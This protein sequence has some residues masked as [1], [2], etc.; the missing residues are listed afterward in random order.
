[1][2]A[3]MDK[4]EVVIAAPELR[5]AVTEL[6]KYPDLEIGVDGPAGTGKTFGILYFI[7][8]LLLTYPGAKWLVARKRNTDLA[9]SALATY[10]ESILDEREGVTFF[11]GS[12][13][14]P[15]GF[16]YPNGSFLAVNGLDRPG[17]VKSMDFDGIYINEATD[18]TLDDVEM[19]H[20][21][22][23]RRKSSALPERFQK[24]LMDFN[25][26]A[27]THFLNQRMNAGLTHRLLSRHE[28]NP[29]LYDAM[30][31]DWTPEGKRYIGELETL[32]GARL[33]RYRY[34]IWASS[35]GMVY[36]DAW[37]RQRNL[38][39]K[40]HIPKEWPRYLSVD[41]GYTNPFVCQWWAQDPDGRLYRY[42]EI[43]KTKTLVE[44]HC[45]DI[46]I[47]S[48][49]FHLLPRNHEKYKVR[50]VDWA[51]PLP[52]D[53]V[54]DHD[55][56]DR[57]TFERHLGLYTTPA[58]KTV[59]DGIQAV[60]SRLKPQGDGKPRLYFLRDALVER[61]PDL[62]QRKLPTCFEEEIDSYVWAQTPS[63]I[64]E[65]PVKANDHAQDAC[66]YITAYFDLVPH[67]VTYF[68]NIWR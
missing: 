23:A 43:Y 62:A 68:Q 59:S 54:C 17:K 42:R 19:C 37:D 46:A 64:K 30:K 12:K 38:I 66:R 58:K 4:T 36:Q 60:A 53:I 22:L 7:H 44:D 10:R 61:D 65:E 14:K 50:P 18:C 47:Q 35:E 67:K 24:L 52:R 34:G 32:T 45:L 27:P 25:P 5:G 1:M 9:G 49:W 11:G 48:G 20:I 8:V 40:R 29:F 63:G 15:P 6:T 13:N 56:E 3:T 57:A 33:A 41:F 28:D 21:R 31:Q 2:I 26:D 16:V 55:A 51:D 39:D